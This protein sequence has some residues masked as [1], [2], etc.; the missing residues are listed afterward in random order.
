MSRNEEEC[1]IY[2]KCISGIDDFALN[3][4]LD[5]PVSQVQQEIRQ[6]LPDSIVSRV[7]ISSTGGININPY[8]TV[9]DLYNGLIKSES[10]SDLQKFLNLKINICLCGGK[11][12]FG[13]MLKVKAHSMN[14]KN[15]RRL[16]S[17]SKDLYKTLDGRRVK[18]IKKIKQL[19]EYMNTLDEESKTR[20]SEKKAKLQ[21]ILDI[22]L[23]KNVKYE[24]TKFLEDIETQLEEI[25]ESVKL[26]DDLDLIS[27]SETDESDDES[28]ES[29]NESD[30]GSVGQGSSSSSKSTV[31]NRRAKMT[32]F[33]D[34]DISESETD[35]KSKGKEVDE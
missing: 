9:G 25:R 23:N 12:G 32:N 18:T 7:S 27:E 11:G 13:Q 15:K 30:N 26:D 35:N 31:S 28:D 24:D 4:P 20:I 5:T 2:V 33:F 17:N 3:F 14:K 19:D 10:G 1:T 29:D 21:K 8:K 16:K 34:D 6:N 22:D